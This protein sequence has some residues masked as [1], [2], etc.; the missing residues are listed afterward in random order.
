LTPKPAAGA[1]PV[2]HLPYFPI[3]A[4]VSFTLTTVGFLAAVVLIVHAAWTSRAVTAI[5]S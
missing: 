2:H 3:P 1:P 5:K 4:A